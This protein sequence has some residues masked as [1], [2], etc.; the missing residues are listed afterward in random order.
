MLYRRRS[1][2]LYLVL[3]KSDSLLACHRWNFGT[4]KLLKFPRMIRVAG[5][6]EHLALLCEFSEAMF[7]C[8]AASRVHVGEW[9]VQNEEAFHAVDAE[10]LDLRIAVLGPEKAAQRS[11]EDGKRSPVEIY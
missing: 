8:T 7:R 5:E 1:D 2:R 11:P 4:G 9:V 10:I 3:S 6:E